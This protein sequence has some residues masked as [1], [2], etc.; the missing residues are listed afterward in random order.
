MSRRNKE[1]KVA[2]IGGGSSYT[3]ELVEGLI[4]RQ[5][6]L[7]IKDL[8]LVDVEAG[9][10]KLEIVGALARRMVEK[11]GA[12]IN[13]HLT[14]DRKEALRDADF[15][16]TQLRVGQLEAR[17]R[18]ERIPLAHGCIGQE[19]TGAGGFAK[20]LR[21]IPVILD[22]CREMKELAP[23]AFLLNFT[24]P[25]G[26][27]TE[28]VLKHGRVPTIGLCNL[29][30]GQRMQI[31][32]AYGVDVSR[33]HVEMVGINHLTWT[34]RIWVDGEDVT[35]AFLRLA[36]GASG[37]TMK[38][39]PDLGWD[40]AFL[41]S[42]GALPCGYH[43]YYYMKDEILAKQLEDLRS[44]G[45]R[46]DEVMKVEAELFELYKDPNLAIKPPQLEKRG[47]AY[48]SEVAVNLMSSIH[49]DKKDIQTVNVR[50]R[51]I[52]S[53]LPD[54]ACIEV[55]SIIGSEGAQPLQLT[56]EIGP[57]IR[58]LLQVVKAYEELTVEAAVKGDYGAALQALTIHPLVGSSKLAQT[59]LD[60][61][62]LRNERYLPQFQ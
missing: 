51:G 20:A 46:A 29:P 14:L 16:S 22:I 3:P 21:T 12:P 35:E 31:A 10:E 45:T 41:R 30:I 53:C 2:V 33:V 17:S 47:G 26:I 27:V 40:D 34:N 49:N 6:E 58:G 4:K 32:D 23:N 11:A 7:P 52:I 25:A 9:R 50:N 57:Q 38:N 44:V 42:L 13:V 55:N 8:Y 37:L 18:D 61:I 19:T 1:L 62:L 59:I 43:R 60:E 54:D 56:R 24:N 5:A 36:A 39:I 28:A 48:Y 15:V